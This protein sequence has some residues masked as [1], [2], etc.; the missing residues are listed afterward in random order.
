[1][2]INIYLPDLGQTSTLK[3]FTDINEDMLPSDFFEQVASSDFGTTL[4]YVTE[5]G[6]MFEIVR[7]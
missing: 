7:L 5:S 3:T 6:R 2:S 4:H 1:M